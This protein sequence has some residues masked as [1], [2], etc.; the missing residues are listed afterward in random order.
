MKIF[1][2]LS[3]I[4]LVVEGLSGSSKVVCSP[5]TVQAHLGQDAVLSCRVETPSDLRAETLEWKHGPDVVHVYRSGGDNYDD[6]DLRF[7][8]R[9]ILNH[10]NLKD[11]NV[12]LTLTN[13]TKEEEGNYTF[14]LRNHDISSNVTLTVVLQTNSDTR[15]LPGSGLSSDVI[16]AVAVCIV[17]IG[18][19]VAV[20][21][22][23]FIVSGVVDVVDVGVGVFGIVL[24]VAGVFIAAILS[25]FLFKEK[26]N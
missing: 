9:T 16:N 15:D 5:S 2:L 3:V 4:P 8:N 26:Q 7:K 13:V 25:P 22:V 14:C 10:Q 11:G 12:S 20:V 24:S 18:I 1:Y 17:S 23:V 21:G 19:G 6:Q